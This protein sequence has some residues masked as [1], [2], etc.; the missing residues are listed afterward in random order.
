[1]AKENSGWDA[2]T[3]LNTDLRTPTLLALPRNSLHNI[4][5]IDVMPNMVRHKIAPIKEGC[6]EVRKLRVNFKTPLYIPPDELPIR[7]INGIPFTTGL[8]V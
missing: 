5:V 4:Q 3:V 8:N 2:V 1:M 6:P 7:D